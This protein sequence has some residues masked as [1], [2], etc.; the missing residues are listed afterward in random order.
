MVAILTNLFQGYRSLRL[1][2]LSSVLWDDSSTDP[3]VRGA[4]VRKRAKRCLREKLSVNATERK[5]L[6]LGQKV[7]APSWLNGRLTIDR[8]IDLY[9]LSSSRFGEKVEKPDSV[10]KTFYPGGCKCFE[11]SPFPFSCLLLFKES[12]CSFHRLLLECLCDVT[13]AEDRSV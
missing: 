5:L 13:R 9:N 7:L 1:P 4:P 6:W 2:F 12:L 3:P 10:V 8:T 11:P